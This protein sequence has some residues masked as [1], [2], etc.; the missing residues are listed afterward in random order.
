MK[1]VDARG[2]GYLNFIVPKQRPTRRTIDREKIGLFQPSIPCIPPFCSSRACN[3]N[4]VRV[5][6][7]EQC[8]GQRERVD[9]SLMHRTANLLPQPHIV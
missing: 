9:E 4:Y 1:Y 5:R 2:N 3:L 8:R 6:C 7:R